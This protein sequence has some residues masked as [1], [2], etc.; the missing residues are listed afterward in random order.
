[1]GCQFDMPGLGGSAKITKEKNCIHSS[2]CL[3]FKVAFSLHL[4][5]QL[6]ARWKLKNLKQKSFLKIP[7]WPQHIFT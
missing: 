7:T 4:L 6:I 1:M 3:K 5:K 2:F